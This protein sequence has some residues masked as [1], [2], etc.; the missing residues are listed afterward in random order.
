MSG[1]L[2]IGS[3]CLYCPIFQI[4][5]GIVSLVIVFV[6]NKYKDSF[7]VVLGLNTVN[8]LNF[9]D[10]LFHIRPFEANFAAIYIQ[11]FKLF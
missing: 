2:L 3:V 8:Q 11:V 10:T 9:M 4:N 5:T 7:N 6:L 1:L